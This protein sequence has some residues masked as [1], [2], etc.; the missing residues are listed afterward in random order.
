MRIGA[1]S[2]DPTLA[3]LSLLD[4]TGAARRTAGKGGS[5][6]AVVQYAGPLKDEWVE[7]VRKTGVEVVSYMAQNGQLVSGDAAALDR[8]GA[9]L[10]TEPFVRAVTPY[11]AADK[12]LPGLDTAGR[13]RSWSRR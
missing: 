9:L 6:L 7:T 4:K 13:A 10:S 5:G 2:A 3:W 12:R 11:T 1:T 8:L